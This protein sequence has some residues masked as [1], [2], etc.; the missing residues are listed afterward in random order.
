MGPFSG[1]ASSKHLPPITGSSL[2]PIAGARPLGSTGERGSGSLLRRFESMRV[3]ADAEDGAGAEAGPLSPGPVRRD[4]PSPGG[5]AAAPSLGRSSSGRNRLGTPALGG[6]AAGGSLMQLAQ[7]TRASGAPP[8]PLPAPSIRP[9]PSLG[10]CSSSL[11]RILDDA[12]EQLLNYV[13]A[14]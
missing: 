13:E 2:P 1:G 7:A 12:D 4:R 10:P 11:P 14:S 9:S 8:A 3:P 5:A 6:G